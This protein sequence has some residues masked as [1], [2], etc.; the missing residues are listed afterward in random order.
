MPNYDFGILIT[1]NIALTL[2]GFFGAMISV[3][4]I[5]RQAGR[6]ARELSQESREGMREIAAMQREVAF[7]IRRQYGDIDRDLQDIKELLGGQ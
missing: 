4:V 5:I 3:W 1:F 6:N 2:I 7:M